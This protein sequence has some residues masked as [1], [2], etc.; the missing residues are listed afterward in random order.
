M[1]AAISKSKAM[2]AK[3]HRPTDTSPI[4]IIAK[5]DFMV[6]RKVSDDQNFL[7]GQTA[8]QKGRPFGRNLSFYSLIT[9]IV[10]RGARIS[11]FTFRNKP[12]NVPKI[13][14]F[15]RKAAYYVRPLVGDLPRNPWKYLPCDGVSVLLMVELQGLKAPL[16]C[17]EGTGLRK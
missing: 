9:R 16:R 15:S 7:L 17:A 11:P 3:D 6:T 4:S 13:V 14:V 8:I 2:I 12:P 10:R 1:N 5:L